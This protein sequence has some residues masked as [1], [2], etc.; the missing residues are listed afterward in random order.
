MLSEVLSDLRNFSFVLHKV[1][2][3][4]KFLTVEM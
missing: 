2:Y 4:V 3:N 1:I